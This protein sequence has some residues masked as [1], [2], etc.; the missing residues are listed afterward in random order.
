LSAAV[1][2]TIPSYLSSAHKIKSLSVTRGLDVM[3]FLPNLPNVKDLSI[4]GNTANYS[5]NTINIAVKDYIPIVETLAI[6]NATFSNSILDFR[7]CNRL[8]LINLQGC[9]GV[10]NIIFPEN[11]R[12]TTVYLPNGLKQL[13]LGVN[14]NLSTFEIPDG[15]KLTTLSLDCSDFNPN[16]DYIDLLTNKVDYSN[17]QSFVVNNTPQDGLVITEDIANKLAEVQLD[18]AVQ[19]SIKGKFIIRHHIEH[20]DDYGNITYTWGE[21]VAIS[22]NTKKKLVQAFKKIDSETNA[23]YFDF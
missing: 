20:E 12:L 17:L 15:T 7:N 3:H 16:F 1:D 23:V 9:V 11:N 19:K 6:T 14:P 22:Y 21:K 2:T 5:V 8:S 13:S 18:K 10:Q 4:D